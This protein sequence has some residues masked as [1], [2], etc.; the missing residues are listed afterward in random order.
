[1]W[2]GWQLCYHLASFSTLISPTQHLHMFLL[3]FSWLALL[4]F[5]YLSENLTVNK[6]INKCS[7]NMLTP[8]LIL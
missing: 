5:L 8:V 7:L 6:K 2:A 1:M 4:V 3:F